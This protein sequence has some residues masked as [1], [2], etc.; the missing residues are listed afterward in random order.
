[1]FFSFSHP[2]MR[3][4]C[5]SR[6]VVSLI[7]SFVL[8]VS[9]THSFFLSLLS[10]SLI[11]SIV[12][13]VC[14]TRL[15]LL[16]VSLIRSF[17]LIFDSLSFNHVCLTH[18]FSRPLLSLIHSSFFLS[19]CF[20]YPLFVSLTHLRLSSLSI[21]PPQTYQRYRP[22]ATSTTSSSVSTSSA[23]LSSTSSS[24]HRP[25]S[26]TG[27]TSSYCRSSRDTEKGEPRPAELA[28]GTQSSLSPGHGIC[29]LD[30]L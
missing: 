28:H 27:I 4:F 14:F 8:S 7:H 20:T 6:V 21:S 10:L 3:S 2:V 18:S 29:S 25:N 24:L 5:L 30:E 26:L 17:S 1:M 19:L 12:F 16:P 13:S 11:H 15:L 22:S 23:P 9:F